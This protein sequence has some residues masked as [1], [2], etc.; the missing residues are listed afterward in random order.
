MI[1]WS[2]HVIG[3]V[4]CRKTMIPQTVGGDSGT[5]PLAPR[6]WSFLW[7]RREF[8]GIFWWLLAASQTQA[9]WQS[10]VVSS[11]SKCFAD[12]WVVDWT[13]IADWCWSFARGLDSWQQRL[14]SSQRTI[15]KQVHFLLTFLFHPPLG[16]GL[17]GRLKHLRTL[18]KVDFKKSRPTI[19]PIMIRRFFMAS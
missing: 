7:L 19:N 2:R 12:L 9:D 8:L 3:W 16:G 17:E 14:E 10:L 6:C 13:A 5:V 18:I 11:G 15:S 1:C 4:M